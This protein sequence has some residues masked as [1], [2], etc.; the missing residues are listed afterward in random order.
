M[1][2]IS[3]SFI[4]ILVE[5]NFCLHSTMPLLDYLSASA[6]GFELYGMLHS[7]LLHFGHTFQ[8]LFLVGCCW[9]TVWWKGGA[10]QA[11]GA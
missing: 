3:L 10:T 11:S 6:H 9:L 5:A 1:L 4:L 7:R 2:K 8:A